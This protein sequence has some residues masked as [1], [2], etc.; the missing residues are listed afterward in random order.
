MQPCWNAILDAYFLPERLLLA[1]VQSF[2]LINYLDSENNLRIRYEVYNVNI[3]LIW[4]VYCKHY[5][6][7]TCIMLALL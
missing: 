4:H 6:N 7:M 2:R 3:T 1:R 5:F